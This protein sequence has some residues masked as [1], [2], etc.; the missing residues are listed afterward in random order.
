MNQAQWEAIINC[1]AAFDGE[2]FYGVKTTR[3][4]CRPSCRS[5]AP[6]P[7]N[8]SLFSTVGAALDD[9]FRPCKRCKPDEHYLNPDAALVE[10]TKT[11]ITRRLEERLTLEVVAAEL[12]ISPY[13]LHR[14][15]RRSTGITPAD[16]LLRKRIET[17]KEALRTEPKRSITDIA[18]AV[19]F[20]TASHFSTVFHR[21]T[22]QK[23]SD[24]RQYAI[25]TV[26]QPNL[27]T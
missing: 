13:H 7:E 21:E 25:S 10:A 26:E 12:A 8:V 9:G 17:A 24:F 1:D 22:G 27:R 2:F 5:R 4:F 6:I 16:Y 19:G 3:I 15:F 23:P 11:V 20:R 14:V 18:L